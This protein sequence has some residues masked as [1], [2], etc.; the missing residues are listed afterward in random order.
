MDFVLAN[1][2]DPDEMLHDAAFHQGLHF[3]PK[4]LFRG[5]QSTKGQG[6]FVYFS[7]HSSWKEVHCSHLLAHNT[8]TASTSAC[9]EVLLC[10]PTTWPSLMNR[11]VSL[12][13]CDMHVISGFPENVHAA[14]LLSGLQIIG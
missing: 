10:V 6:L 4:Y 5:F 11:Y 1:S 3:L 2:V 13:S 12:E 8:T 14:Y 7:A 9:L